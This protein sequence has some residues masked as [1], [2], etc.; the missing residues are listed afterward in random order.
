MRLNIAR[1]N[2]PQRPDQVV[3]LTRVGASDSV[4]NTDTVDTDL[5]DGAVD[6]EQVDEFGPERVFRG[7]SDL[8]ALGL[9][10]FDNLDGAEL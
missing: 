9:D 8:D 4:G 3:H 7:E 2:T 6:G 1:D 10:E 5:V